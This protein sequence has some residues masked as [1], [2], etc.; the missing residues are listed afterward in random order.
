LQDHFHKP[1]TEVQANAWL[2]RYNEQPGLNPIQGAEDDGH[3]KTM[4]PL[5]RQGL[6]PASGSGDLLGDL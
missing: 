5:G 6:R 1:E 4:A 2:L 3:C